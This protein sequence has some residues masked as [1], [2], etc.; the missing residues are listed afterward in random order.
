M[1]T[2]LEM[3][4]V[5]RLAPRLLSDATDLVGEFTYSQIHPKGGFVDRAGDPDLYYTVFGMDCL[6]ALKQPI[7]RE[8]MIGFLKSFGTGEVLDLIHSC[9]LLRCWANLG[10]PPPEVAAAVLAKV[11]N[12]RAEDG[13][14]H[15]TPGRAR[16]SCYGN[17]LALGAYEAVGRP[18]PNPEL[19][20]ANIHNLATQDGGFNDEPGL[21]LGTMPATAA[22]VAVCRALG[23][24][25]P[26]SVGL[27]MLQQHNPEG[28]FFAVPG[29]PMPDLLSTAVCLHAMSLL[30]VPTDTVKEPCLDFIDSLWV[31]RGAFFG[32]WGDEHLD[33]EYLFYALLALG[34]LSL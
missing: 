10:D 15:V 34:H 16:G 2:R 25:L 29:A 5:A 22:A 9:A 32:N 33:C 7:P 19:V 4:Q 26:P 12:H 6:V 28:G 27:W 3:L 18:L 8:G 14:Y 20:L 30:K 31:N 23:H 17:F 24:H 11:E 21:P 13:G 1:S